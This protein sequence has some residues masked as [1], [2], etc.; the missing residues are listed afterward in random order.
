MNNQKNSFNIYLS[1]WCLYGLQ[2]SLYSSGGFLSQIILAIL[3]TIS[4]Y[5]FV[6]AN[7][8]HKMPSVLK[9]LSFIVCVFSI[10]GLVYMLSGKTYIIQENATNA[11]AYK[12]I[13]NIYISILPIYCAYVNTK[14]GRLKEHDLKIWTFVFLAVA[15]ISFYRFKNDEM[16][17][18]L[19][20]GLTMEDV[21][22]NGSY[23]VLAIV[24]L[25]PLFHNK[26]YLQYSILAIC[27][28][29]VTIGM[30]RGALVCGFAATAYLIIKTIQYKNHSNR[31]IS[32]YILIFAI[33]IF[34]YY[35]V[36]NML[37]NNDYFNNRLES[38][39]EGESSN[40][41][42]LYMV[43]LN[44]LLSE[45]SPFLLLFGN[46]AN[47]TLFIGNNYAHNDWLEIAINNGLIM[48]IAYFVY[49]FKMFK[50][51]RFSKSNQPYGMMIGLFFI[52][53]FFKT[54]FSMSYSDISTWASVALG[55]AI[56]K[57]PVS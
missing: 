45:T 1:L 31:N 32:N 55:Y 49:W 36:N 13:K 33:I 53:Y 51:I 21:T 35:V 8:K 54:M 50:L 22:N 39:L 57:C 9:V 27:L 19:A 26:P 38:T 41:D 48:V 34:L 23:G 14:L 37:M 24:V 43:L 47:A 6:I 17:N 18:I 42:V 20:N 5:Y 30:K 56:A 52:I 3:L 28:Y 7:I 16:A 25:L 40:R 11:S 15:I 29:Y 4:I 10:Y 46:G 44:H 12:Y 2:G